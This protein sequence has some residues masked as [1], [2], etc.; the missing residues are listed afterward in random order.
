MIRGEEEV[1]ESPIPAEA[2]TTG[3]DGTTFISSSYKDLV[4]TINNQVITARGS[5][6]L[7]KVESLLNMLNNGRFYCKTCGYESH[8]RTN[9]VVHIGFIHGTPPC[10]SCH[11]QCFGD[12]VVDINR[13]FNESQFSA[14]SSPTSTHPPSMTISNWIKFLGEYS[15]KDSVN[16][17]LDYSVIWRNGKLTRK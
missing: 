7:S 13:N 2:H 10:E 4:L 9:L 17:A 11:D 16:P 6:R 15:P 12:C 14:Q 3:D 1:T 5:A 8:D